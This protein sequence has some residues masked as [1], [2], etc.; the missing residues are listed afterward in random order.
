MVVTILDCLDLLEKRA[1]YKDIYSK[2]AE[3]TF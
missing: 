2:L 1:L 3:T